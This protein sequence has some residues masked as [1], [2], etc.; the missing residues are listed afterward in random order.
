MHLGKMG[1]PV[2]TH[3]LLYAVPVSV[4]DAIRGYP[5]LLDF[6]QTVG[7]IKWFVMGL[8]RF[9]QGSN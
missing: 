6:Q 8:Q 5:P 1:F 2:N 7:Q 3:H 4:L 9:D